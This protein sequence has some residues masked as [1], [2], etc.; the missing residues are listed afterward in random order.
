MVLGIDEDLVIPNKLASVYEG[1]VA[2]WKGEKLGQLERGL[3]RAAR[4]A[5]FPVHNLLRI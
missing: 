3:V 5:D 4:R 2:P 1:S